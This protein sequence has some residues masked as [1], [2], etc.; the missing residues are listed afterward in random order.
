MV[1]PRWPL[2]SLLMR[3][4]NGVGTTGERIVRRLLPLL[5]WPS[6][7]IYAAN[8]ST[9]AYLRYLPSEVA[10]ILYMC[11]YRVCIYPGSQTGLVASL[12]RPSQNVIKTRRLFVRGYMQFLRNE[13]PG[14]R[15]ALAGATHDLLMECF[16]GLLDTKLPRQNTLVQLSICILWELYPITSQPSMARTCV[17]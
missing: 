11:V 7:G 8:L 3:D 12:P 1:C 17:A 4:S 2:A 6:F 14:S 5:W 10:Y 9:D 16:P 15:R 13:N